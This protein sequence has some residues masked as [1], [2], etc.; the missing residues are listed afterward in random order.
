MKHEILQGK[1]YGGRKKAKKEVKREERGKRKDEMG[2]KMGEKGRE[3]GKGEGRW[4]K[5][6]RKRGKGKPP[7]HH[8]F[9]RE[10]WRASHPR[11]PKIQLQ[12]GRKK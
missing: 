11:P 12:L 5:G 10:R 3:G 2:R 7:P 9:M 8:L 1:N 6:E 4:G